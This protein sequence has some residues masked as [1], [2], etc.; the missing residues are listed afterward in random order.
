MAIA[1]ESTTETAIAAGLSTVITK[2]SGLAVGDYMFAQII[3]ANSLG[4]DV[5]SG[6]TALY[7][8]DNALSGLATQTAVFYKQATSGDVAA[9]NFT[10]T[11]GDSAGTEYIGGTIIRVSGFGM[12]DGTFTNVASPYTTGSY[13][14]PS[15]I[16]P[17]FANDLVVVFFFAG[18]NAATV[19]HPSFNTPAVATDNPTWTSRSADSASFTAVTL[20]RN[21]FTASRAA[22][23]AFGNFSFNVDQGSGGG[24]G[25]VTVLVSIAP[26]ISGTHSVVTGTSYIVNQPFLRSGAISTDGVDPVTARYDVTS[27]QN[28]TKD[29]TTWTDQVK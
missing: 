4:I 2:P 19:T 28:Q 3:A 9:S 14:N 18:D 24:F 11:C 1:Y 7:N 12:L 5:P 6:W 20:A 8:V 13:S 26:L 16:D 22:T 10:F 15:G 29:P 27:W 17:V 25:A 23:T 21:L